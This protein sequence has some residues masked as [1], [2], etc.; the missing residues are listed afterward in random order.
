LRWN[1]SAAKLASRDDSIDI[2]AS[3]G[4]DEID[5]RGLLVRLPNGTPQVSAERFSL[6]AT[7]ARWSRPVRRRQV[8]PVPAIAGIWPFGKGAIAFREA[9]P[10]DACRTAV[11]SAARSKAQFIYP[12]ES[13]RSGR[14]GSP[15]R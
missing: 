7:S 9:S 13:T 1:R 5:L 15:M 10:D 14:T 4:G 11:F 12:A 6:R 3:T 8:D 2:V